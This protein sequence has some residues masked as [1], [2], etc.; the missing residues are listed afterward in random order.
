MSKTK[1]QFL[2]G[3]QFPASRSPR[4]YNL[5][6]IAMDT[7][8]AQVLSEYK[9]KLKFGIQA[10]LDYYNS[11]DLTE[12]GKGHLSG[13]QKAFDL[14]PEGWMVEIDNACQYEETDGNCPDCFK[15]NLCK[16]TPDKLIERA[17]I[18]GRSKQSWTDFKAD[19][20][21]PESGETLNGP[22]NTHPARNFPEDYEQENGNYIN[23]CSVCKL[24]FRGNKHRVWCRM[25]DEPN[26][27]ELSK[28][29]KPEINAPPMARCWLEGE[30]VGFA[31]CMV[32]RVKPLQEEIA[33]LKSVSPP[34]QAESQDWEQEKL[35]SEMLEIY[36]I[37]AIRSDVLK[38]FTITRKAKP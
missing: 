6:L 12:R 21:I 29:Q 25:C 22:F 16:I 18:A 4:D 8:A 11:I 2:E 20:G 14:L 30:M 7:Y 23:T 15:G 17:F 24:P 32:K 31:R 33:R 36:S 1:E 13:L 37:R 28:I 38:E 10:E 5:T 9:E 3:V 35:F 26:W 34:P 19:A 27:E